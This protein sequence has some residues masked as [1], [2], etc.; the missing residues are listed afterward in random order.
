[1]KFSIASTLPLAHGI[2][3]MP[4]SKKSNNEE[5]TLRIQVSPSSNNIFSPNNKG[6]VDINKKEYCLIDC[7]PEE[8]RCPE[9]W[10]TPDFMSRVLL[11][12]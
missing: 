10:W 5:I 6:V 3:A 8:T 9:N 2:T 12:N 11:Y 1:M 7:I 4:W